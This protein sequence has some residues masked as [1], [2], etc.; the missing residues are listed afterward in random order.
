ML[1]LQEIRI[2]VI[3]LGY[4]GLPLAVEFGKKRVVLGFD[5]NKKRLEDLKNGVDVTN[6]TTKDEIM[7]STNLTFS[8]SQDDLKQCNTFIVTV[9]TPVDQNKKP[10]LTMILLASK[11]VGMHLSKGDI[12]I[13]E[14]TVY[15]GT[16]EE[17]CVPVLEQ[18]S[19][20]RFNKDFYCGYSPER[21][22]PGDKEHTLSKITKIT[23]GSTKE[24]ADLIDDLYMEIIEA[25]THK[26]E[27]IKIAEA[28]K[29]I[30]NT[31]RDL[32]IAL[33]NELSIIFRKMNIDTD[34]VLKASET[35]WNFLPFKPG[36]VG[37]HCIG[38]D[39]YYLTYKSQ[40][41]GYEPQVILSGRNLNDGMSKYVAD[42]MIEM[43]KSKSESSSIKHILILGLTF[44]EN[45]PDIRNSKIVDLVSSFSK[46]SYIIDVYDPWV[47]PAD[48]NKLTEINLITDL[49]DNFYD[50]II[51]AVGHQIF[52]DMGLK[53]IK[54]KGKDES[55]FF[56][57]KSLFNKD[58]SDFRL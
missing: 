40:M 35:K 38:V 49:K 17:E 36:L 24:A 8:D 51:L 53:T 16:T 46:Q 5:L 13:Y 22:N 2:G 26:A 47:E 41:M 23:S 43:L 1:K 28:A 21:I 39:P 58:N 34:S 6:E 44:K 25:G 12:V 32:N 15:P 57:L 45:C 48:V 42:E 4:V 55:I 10:D 11:T 54:T 19:G 9:P 27:T 18:F 37:G 3:G 7:S 29:V 20:L 56:D 30:E 52:L 33:M 50:G 14:S 31:Q